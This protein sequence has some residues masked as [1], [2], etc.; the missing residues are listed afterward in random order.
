M[1]QN[2]QKC[3]IYALLCVLVRIKTNIFDLKINVARFARNVLK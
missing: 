1:F 3:L 2:Y